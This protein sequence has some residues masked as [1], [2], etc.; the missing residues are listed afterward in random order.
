MKTHLNNAW[1]MTKAIEAL[2]PDEV[3]EFANELIRRHK[4]AL[5]ELNIQWRAKLNAVAQID[6]LT[7]VKEASYDT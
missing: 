2:K 4:I 3:N 6:F 1:E 7:K 5:D